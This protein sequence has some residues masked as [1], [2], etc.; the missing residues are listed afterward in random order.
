MKNKAPFRWNKLSWITSFCSSSLTIFFLS[1]PT[2]NSKYASL[3]SISDDVLKNNL[4]EI[5]ESDSRDYSFYL[6]LVKTPYTIQKYNYFS[7]KQ[8]FKAGVSNSFSP[9]ATSA[10]RLPSKG[11]MQ[12]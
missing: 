12:F 6:P 3:H 4:I 2:S 10:L 5:L 11:R 9:G 8:M 7:P 1:L